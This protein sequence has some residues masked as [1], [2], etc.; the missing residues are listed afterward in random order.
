[1]SRQARG[2]GPIILRS[3]TLTEA[4]LNCRLCIIVSVFLA[5]A[6]IVGCLSDRD[7]YDIRVKQHV[8]NQYRHFNADQNTAVSMLMSADEWIISRN[9]LNS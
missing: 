4:L 3:S 8:S 5:E 1:M 6:Q 2:A 7:L 9:I